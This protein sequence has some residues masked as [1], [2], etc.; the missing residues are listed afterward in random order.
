MRDKR[1]SVIIWEITHNW[2]R[3]VKVDEMKR[4]GSRSVSIDEMMRQNARHNIDD[5][6]LDRGRRVNTV[7]LIRDW[8]RDVNYKNRCETELTINDATEIEV[9]TMTT[10]IT[11][12]LEWTNT[13]G[14]ERNDETRDEMAEFDVIKKYQQLTKY[15]RKHGRITGSCCQRQSIIGEDCSLWWRGWDG[16]FPISRVQIM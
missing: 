5:M 13:S 15:W 9:S 2:G 12:K 16:I 7:K 1:Q 11:T 10:D 8:S 4:D 3:G 14:A 6:M